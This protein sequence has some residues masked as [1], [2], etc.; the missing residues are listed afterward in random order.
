[1]NALEWLRRPPPDERAD[2]A[3]VGAPIH[4]ASI[5][6]SN[7]HLTPP[8]FR[9]ALARFAT[10]DGDH[11][12]QLAR[13]GALDLGDVDGDAGDE[14]ASAAHAR[15]EEAVSRAATRAAVVAIVGGDN[16]LTRPAMNG[17][18][19]HAGLAAGWGLLTVDAHHDCRPL[20]GGASN[21][22]P[23]R[24]L[25]VDGLPGSRVAQVGISGF[26]NH[27]DQAA[28]AMAQGVMV[29]RASEVRQAGMARTIEQAL[30]ELR[31]A[32]VSDIYADVDIDV[33]DRAFA[34]ACPASMPGGL[35]PA[36]LQQAAYRLGAEPM[37]RAVDLVEVDFGADING[38]TVRLMA[39]VFLAF[40]AGVATR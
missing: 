3:L 20:D 5:S 38:M 24:G 14:D 4:Q 8:A 6:P 18:A 9:E 40:C 22:T 30:L 17:L 36:E 28:W 23:V 35:H 33:V 27:E 25:I 37:V 29:H 13:L 2:I 34:P 21:G 11:G 39:S 31:A 16:S 26:A 15:I 32:G 19:R 12:V 10:W 7:A 1:M